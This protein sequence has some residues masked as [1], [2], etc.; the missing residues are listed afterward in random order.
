MRD[1]LEEMSLNGMRPNRRSYLA[2]LYASMRGRKLGDAMFF[3]EEMRRHGYEP[4]VGA[5]VSEEGGCWAGCWAGW[6]AAG[7]PLGAWFAE[8]AGWMQPYG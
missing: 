2:G 1:V 3:W 5:G 6:G 4:D 8:G 7:P